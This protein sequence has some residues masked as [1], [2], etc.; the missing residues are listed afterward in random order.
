MASISCIRSLRA[1]SSAPRRPANPPVFLLSRRYFKMLRMGVPRSAI[2]LKMLADGVSERDV[3]IFETEGLED[4]SEEGMAARRAASRDGVTTLFLKL[5]GR[6]GDDAALAHKRRR[7]RAMRAVHWEPLADAKL[8][9]NSDDLIAL[10]VRRGP[11]GKRSARIPREERARVFPPR[12]R[13]F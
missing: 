7:A 3:R 9:A 1:I 11:R 4:L 13:S 12:A 8:L 10:Q 6:A 2:C 5:P